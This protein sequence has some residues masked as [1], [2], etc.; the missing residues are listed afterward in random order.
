MNFAV[1]PDPIVVGRDQSP[2]DF[3]AHLR[4]LPAGWQGRIAFDTETTGIDITKDVPLFASVSDGVDRWLLKLEH[5]ISP[6]FEQLVKDPNRVWVM[7]NS[8]F[9][10]HMCANAG[11]PEFAGDI[12]DVI[13][14]C[15]LRD[16][17][18]KG[19]AGL[20]LKEQARDYLNIK[21]RPFKDVFDIKVKASDEGRALLEADI[22]LVAAYASLDAYATWLLSEDHDGELSDCPAPEGN[23]GGYITLN[24]YFWD[25]EVPFTKTLW[26]MERRGVIID[27]D[28]LQELRQPMLERKRDLL[29][30]IMRMAQ[31]PI[32]PNS[33]QQLRSVFFDSVADGGLGLT[34]K[35]FTNTGAP[36][37]DVSVLQSLAKTVPLAEA[38]LEYRKLVKILGTYVDGLTEAICPSTRRIHTS[39]RQAGT[40]TGRLSSARPNLQNIPARGDIG[41]L[42]REAFTAE[43]DNALIVADYSQME[44]CVMAHVSNDDAMITAISDGLDLHSFTASRMLGVE[45]DDVVRAKKLSDFE[46]P[47]E[48]YDYAEK[49]YGMG[50][51]DTD[52]L[53]LRAK[54]LLSAR[55]AAKAIGF[56]LMYGRGPGALADELGV[57]RKEARELIDQWFQTFPSVR[58]YIDDIQRQAR[59]SDDHAVYTVFGRPRRLTSITSTQ[60]GVR[61]KAERDA[62]NSPIQGSASCIIKK[63][64]ILIDKDTELGGDC[65]EGGSLGCKLLLQVH[66]EIMLECPQG[67]TEWVSEKMKEIMV[68]AANLRVPLK[69][70]G[71]VALNWAAAK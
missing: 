32:N 38:L 67:V 16:E 47:D 7:A 37:T 28:Y 52:A 13:V 9:D 20:G 15:A 53:M 48:Q 35:K 25:L 21:M 68:T 44:M 24:N 50:M 64:M 17:N 31:R 57:T 4:Q 41:A 27:I 51:L 12:V 33:T 14:Q 39:F 62:I 55:N 60:H 42:I 46:N 26:R 29:G 36:S 65:L 3:F 58:S 69:A 43:G 1:L 19:G 23:L 22:D 40:V 10:M 61:A 34:P 63:A 66:D 54:E 45:Y 8:K 56:G 59:E 30:D 49:A 5:L 6:E 71:G 2:A 11:L 70:T 18:R